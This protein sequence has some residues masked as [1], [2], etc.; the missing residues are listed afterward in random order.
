MSIPSTSIR[1]VVLFV[2][3]VTFGVL[4]NM[5]TMTDV[6]FTDTNLALDITKVVDNTIQGDTQHRN[7]IPTTQKVAGDI[8]GYVSHTNADWLFNGILY[9]NN[10]LG[11]GNTAN[12]GNTQTSFSI[13]VGATDISQYMLFTGCVFD[14]LTLTLAPAALVTYKASIIGQD[15]T[16]STSTNSANTLP[17]PQTA[18]M[19]SVNGTIKEGGSIVAYIS[20]CTFNFDRKHTPNYALGNSECVSIST[21]FFDLTGTA[22]VYLEDQV[23]YNKFLNNTNSSLDFT[24][25]DGTNT[26]EITLPKI[27]YTTAAADIKGT[28]PIML[29]MN[30][31]A[32]RDPVTGTTCTITRS[33]P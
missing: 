3:E 32:V 4:P 1:T 6:P 28:G 17:A 23:M 5:P 9:A 16:L 30:F 13:E 11:T 20:G 29:K 7:V 18:P 14:K 24:L 12:V 21:S 2:P 8:G 33:G 26:Y 25:S 19:A 27:Y 31:T 10:S 22:E 15:L